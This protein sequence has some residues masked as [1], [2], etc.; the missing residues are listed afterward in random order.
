MVAALFALHPLHVESVAW[1][2]E[3]KDVLSALFW[4]LTL[5]AYARYVA[6]PGPA[7]YCVDSAGV[8]PGVDGQA[9]GSNPAAGAPPAG[10]L[11]LRAGRSI[12]ARNCRSWPCPP[13]SRWSRTR[14]TQRPKRW[15]RWRRS[16]SVCAWRTPWFR[17]PL[18]SARC[19][20]QRARDILPLP[21]GFARL[22]RRARRRGNRGGHGG[23]VWMARKRPYLIVGW[24]WYLVTLA[25]VIGLIQAGQQSRA[26]RYMYIP[27]IGLSMASGLGRGGT[28]AR[29]A[30]GAGGARRGGLCGVCR[31]DVVAGGLLARRSEVVSARGG[32]DWR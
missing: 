17:T 14:F 5:G 24:L 4:M 16:R 26:D 1:I 18:T 10:L 7:R 28:A 25:P 15:S 9:H 6:R 29:A 21:H 12:F 8:L 3:R 13:L 22:S 32:C 20:A 19:L 31:G 30:A 2:A 23:G 27:M 11:A